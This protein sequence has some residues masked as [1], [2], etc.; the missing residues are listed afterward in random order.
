VKQPVPARIV[1]GYAGSAAGAASLRDLV[2]AGR[3]VV[4]VT[5]DIGQSRDVDEVRQQALA[6][7]ALRA[8]VFDVREEFARDCLL[9]ILR[10]RDLDAL[11][12]SVLARPLV[13]RKLAEVAAIEQAAA[14][15]GA[16]AFDRVEEPDRAGRRSRSLL[17][18]PVADPASAPDA[19]AH[20]D[21][22]VDNGIPVAINGVPLTV[23]EL[24]ESLALIAGRH[25]IGRLAHIDA[26]AAPPL[27]AAYV[28]LTADSGIVGFAL[29]KGHLTLLPAGERSRDLVNHA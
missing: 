24:L 4:T 20:V 6:A 21:L 8:H 22:H 28:A 7:G 1:L 13:E 16:D 11:D 12:G 27:H 26:P 29:H 15:L 18:R 14:V 19:G 25:G 3:E 2:A 5:L 23:A 10:S 17:E 9:P